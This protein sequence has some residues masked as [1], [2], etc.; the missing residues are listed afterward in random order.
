MQFP[1]TWMHM[2]HI[3]FYDRIQKKSRIGQ[4]KKQPNYLKRLLFKDITHLLSL[5]GFLSICVFVKS[6]RNPRLTLDQK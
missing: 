1:N 5:Y 3:H 6:Y 2:T 4:K